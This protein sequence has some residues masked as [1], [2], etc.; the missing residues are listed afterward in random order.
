[1]QAV[2]YAFQETWSQEEVIL[3]PRKNN[4]R[5]TGKGGF[6]IMH[7]PKMGTAVLILFV[8]L[9]V[10]VCQLKP[11]LW[12][13]RPRMYLSDGSVELRLYNHLGKHTWGGSCRDVRI[14]EAEV[15]GLCPTKLSCDSPLALG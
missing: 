4:A 10:Q 12:W 11:G 14:P 3:R 9:L 1:M 2:P 5:N 15:Q 6:S 8:L 13:Y 7:R